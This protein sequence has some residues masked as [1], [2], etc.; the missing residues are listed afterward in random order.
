MIGYADCAQEAT[1]ISP[2]RSQR[3]SSSPGSR[4]YCAGR[5]KARDTVLRVGPLEL[6]LIERTRHARRSR[7]RFCCRANS[8][9]PNT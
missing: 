6:D 5:R 8:A 2:S 3:S 4:R 1:T 9:A 7:D